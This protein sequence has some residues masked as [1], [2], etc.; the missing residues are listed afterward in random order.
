MDCLF[1]RQVS[2]KYGTPCYCCGLGVLR[3]L[4]G[5][6]KCPY[7]LLL[8]KDVERSLE[9]EPHETTCVDCNRR[10]S[11]NFAWDAYN[12]NGDCLAEK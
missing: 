3:K 7:F 1:D 5:K 6:D 4:R 11:C 12:T 2:K 10:H 8:I 9:P